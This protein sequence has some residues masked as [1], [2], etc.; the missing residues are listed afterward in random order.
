MGSS[1]PRNAGEE[2]LQR[3]LEAARRVGDHHRA[4]PDER[5]DEQHEIGRAA[6]P[7]LAT[8][9]SEDLQHAREELGWNVNASV[10]SG[11]RH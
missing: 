4:Q 9:R 8:R 11:V 2:P 7:R 10:S 5:A 3:E 6:R 1:Q